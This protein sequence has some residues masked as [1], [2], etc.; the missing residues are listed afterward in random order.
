M[1]MSFSI[2]TT[3][4]KNDDYYHL[5]SRV[6]SETE[7]GCADGIKEVERIFAGRKTWVR[8]ISEPSFDKEYGADSGLWFAWVRVSYTDEAG[9]RIILPA[10][11]GNIMML[12]GDDA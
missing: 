8:R 12:G 9:D 7:S 5:R 4:H 3:V 1:A 6:V 2:E 11:E 10:H